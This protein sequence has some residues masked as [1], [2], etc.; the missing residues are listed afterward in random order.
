MDWETILTATVISAGVSGVFNMIV[1]LLS[2]SRLRKI[3][4]DK[5]EYERG[6][7][8]IKKL[9]TQLERLE[10]MHGFINTV[11]DQYKTLNDALDRRLAFIEIYKIVRPIIFNRFAEEIDKVIIDEEERYSKFLPIYLAQ[12]SLESI[13]TAMQ[14][15]GDVAKRLPDTLSIA[16]RKQI[17]YYFNKEDTPND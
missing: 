9:Y 14:A 4:R 10:G 1:A 8:V 17:G 2:N 6:D 12:E 15:W 13:N 11:G 5:R 16:I 7:Y 3:E